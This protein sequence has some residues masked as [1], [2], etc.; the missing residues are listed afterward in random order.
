LLTIESDELH[1]QV[2]QVDGPQH[3]VLKTGLVTPP[4]DSEDMMAVS[5]VVDQLDL[6]TIW[7]CAR[8]IVRIVQGIGDVVVP[9]H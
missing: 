9:C 5:I 2:L 3:D 4:H 1:R 6:L 8:E 7:H